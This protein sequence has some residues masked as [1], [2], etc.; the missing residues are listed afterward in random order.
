MNQLLSDCPG[1]LTSSDYL[2]ESVAPYFGH[3]SSL[4]LDEAQAVNPDYQIRYCRPVTA[5]E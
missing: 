5:Q 1:F 4:G 2:P 3:S